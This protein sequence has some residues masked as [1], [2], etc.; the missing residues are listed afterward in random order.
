M[1]FI[2]REEVSR[3][4]TYKV[5]IPV[6][7]DAVMA[8]SKGETKRRMFRIMPGAM[9][10][11]AVFG[12]MRISVFPEN[13]ERGIQSH[14]GLVLLF[15]PDMGASVMSIR[16]AARTESAPSHP[17]PSRSCAEPGCGRVQMPR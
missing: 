14:P 4:L 1:R 3:H 7:R 15:D 6:L 11:H 8:L 10:A 5:C 16:T 13:Y 2:D 12:A 17:P 9:G